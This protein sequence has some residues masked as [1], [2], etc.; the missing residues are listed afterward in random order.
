M[1][2]DHNHS[3][4]ELKGTRLTIS[5]ILNIFIT[6]TQVAGGIFSGSLALLTDALH[7]F[8]DVMALIISL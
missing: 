3:H 6:V 5:I 7:N 2:H 4:G 1:S 8:S